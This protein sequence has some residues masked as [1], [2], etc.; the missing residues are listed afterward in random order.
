MN[1]DSISNWWKGLSPQ[2]RALLGAGGGFLGGALISTMFGGSGWLG[3]A[4]GGLAGGAATVDWKALTSAFDKAKQK[5]QDA[6][7]S[8]AKS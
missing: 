1:L 5:K 7:E 4:L 8:T 2:M 6:T 3:G